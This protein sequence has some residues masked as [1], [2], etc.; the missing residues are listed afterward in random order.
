MMSE[1]ELIKL[2]MFLRLCMWVR[3]KEIESVYVC[4]LTEQKSIYKIS[5]PYP[6]FPKLFLI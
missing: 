5:I 3:E 4:V 6:H 1:S 2:C